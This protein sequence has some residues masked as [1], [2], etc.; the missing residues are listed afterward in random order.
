MAKMKYNVGDHVVIKRSNVDFIENHRGDCGIVEGYRET[1]GGYDYLISVDNRPGLVI[2][3]EVECRVRDK[4]SE[5]KAAETTKAKKAAK[6]ANAT[7]TKEKVTKNRVQRMGKFKLGDIVKRINCS[8]NYDDGRCFKVGDIGTVVDISP[9]GWFTVNVNGVD[10]TYVDSRNL[11]V[12]TN[13]DKIVIKHDGKD[14]TATLYRADGTKEVAVARC[15]PE[16]TFDFG[17][18]AKLAVERL[19]LSRPTKPTKQTKY[20]VVDRPI[21]PGDK[22]RIVKP[23]FTHDVVGDILTVEDTGYLYFKVTEKNL[24][25]GLNK[26]ASNHTWYYPTDAVKVLKAVN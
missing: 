16:D 11:E 26:F 1:A 19:M 23:V 14:T 22:V 9:D 18:G 4:K 21:K 3:C 24:P 5:T 15:S 25:H 12:V 20:V 2:W 13:K 8:N 6:A 7:K 10:Y 17:V